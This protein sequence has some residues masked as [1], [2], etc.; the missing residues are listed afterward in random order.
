[1][2]AVKKETAAPTES[3]RPEGQE[4][5][6]PAPKGT[7]EI[8]LSEPDDD[9]EEET[10]AAAQ[11]PD[12]LSPRPSR[13]EKKQQRWK[14]MEERV[15]RAE[16][17]AREARE[18]AS[19]SRQVPQQ[20]YAPQQGQ[21][22][23]PLQV[24]DERLKKEGEDLVDMW[25]HLTSTGKPVPE[26]TQKRLREKADEIQQQRQAIAFHRFQRNQ[27]PDPGHQRQQQT[28]QVLQARYPDVTMHQQATSWALSRAQQLILE[29]NRDDL[30]LAD[31]VFD[32]ARVRFGMKKAPPD[33]GAKRR[34]E[35]IPRGGGGGGDT[36]TFRM[37]PEQQAMADEL[38]EHVKDPKKRYRL[39]AEKMV[40]RRQKRA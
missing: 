12:P 30:A 38:Y 34:M 19:R 25:N 15:E 33:P 14:D 36:T 5:E 7:I 24:E 35:G 21:Q 37:T 27:Q 32:E 28:W 40:A 3:E 13:R 6:G 11:Q 10:P 29:G 4:P 2:A 23:D 20:H 31:R 26:A 1:M 17:E 18:E 16:R 8:D 9:E 22:V 39:Y